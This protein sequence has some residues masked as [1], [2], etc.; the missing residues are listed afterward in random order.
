MKRLF[1]LFFAIATCVCIIW[2]ENGRFN[3]FTWSLNGGTLTISGNGR[4]GSA[5]SGRWPWYEYRKDISNVIISDGI[6]DIGESAFYACSN[7]SYVEMPNSIKEI[8]KYA[9]GFCSSLS[10]IVIPDG[11]EWIDDGAF[12][13][14]GLGTITIPSSVEDIAAYAFWR[15]D[16]LKTVTLNSNTFLSQSF[17]NPWTS[18]T[19]SHRFNWIF[20][21]KVK[22]YIIGEGVQTIGENAFS[23]LSFSSIVLPTTI[24]NIG[25]D[26]FLRC[27]SL[28]SVHI[29][30]LAAWCKINAHNVSPLKYADSL[31]INGNLISDLIIP[32]SVDSIGT[33]IF[34]G[35]KGLFSLTI[36]NSVTHIGEN[37]FAYCKNLNFVTFG[38]NVTS[39]GEY[40]FSGCSNL[41][42]VFIN[43]GVISIDGNVFD[44]CNNLTH[45][46]FNTHTFVRLNET[47]SGDYNIPTSVKRIANSAF[48][49][50]TKL[51]TLTI[52]DSIVSIGYYA[53]YDCNDL[54]SI[55][56]YAIE[57]PILDG[58]YNLNPSKIML[59]VPQNSVDAYKTTENWKDFGS[60][61]PI[62][63]SPTHT[64]TATAVN[65]VV[66]GAGT[67]KTYY[68]IQL[69]AI[70]KSGYRFVKWSDESIENPRE[71]Q[72]L[73]DAEFE[74]LFE[75]IEI[76]SNTVNIPYKEPFSVNI[77]GF[78]IHDVNLGGL[79]YVW[80]LTSN[81]GMKASAYFN[82]SCAAESWLI[83]PPISLLDTKD[84]VLSFQH[85]VNKGT[86]AYLRAKIST[87]FGE[88]WSDLTIPNWPA[89][90]NWNFVSTS[91]LLDAYANKIVQIAFVY[92]SSTSDC[93]TW[94]IKNFSVTGTVVPAKPLP[95][96]VESEETSVDVTWL[97]VSNANS[98]ELIIR[99][100]NGKI[101]HDAEIQ[102]Q[103]VTN[104]APSRDNASQQDQANDFIYTVTGL[105]SDTDYN[106]ILIAKDYNDKV[107]TTY[108]G[109]FRTKGET[110]QCIKDIH[111]DV[112]LTTKVLRDGQIYILRGE[113]AYDSQGKMVK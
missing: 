39:V 44:A 61:L 52:P 6:T 74:A 113:K 72:V 34:D 79:D 105:T 58:Y 63:D 17:D 55:T 107:I 8:W 69:Y 86:T 42:N 102:A 70:P 76:P 100:K 62:P 85:A 28:K 88:S 112:P 25:F 15:C 35:Y 93:P 73:K 46:I 4:M 65:G 59:C 47:Y 108:S 33:H 51:T 48:S 103:S 91:L 80:M 87:D 66:E 83:S 49:N 82:K 81:Y 16:S 29:S 7:L 64:I 12:S 104:Y 26:A 27:D 84:I 111:M 77:G 50:C 10:S 9:F 43:D 30:N 97:T 89:G 110:L 18:S 11:V 13:V 68:S 41:T 20:G 92:K 32:N 37:A 3:G 22:K 75:K 99:E 95:I 1:T 23:C 21:N 57:P 109:S 24:T 45:P 101:I 106:Y 53:F 31:C 98:Y 5:N 54:N 67:H 78:Y 40:A 14:C 96:D 60:I 94:E 38:D 36:S 71:I 56:C 19:G 2:A 90:T